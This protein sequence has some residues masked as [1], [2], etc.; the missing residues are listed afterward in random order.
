M[1]IESL[2]KPPGPAHVNEAHAR[3]GSAVPKANTGE[4]VQLS[5]LASTLQKAEAALAETPEVDGKRIEEIK[6][7]IRDGRFQIDANRIADGLLAEVRQMLD[8]QA[9]RI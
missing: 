9:D 6:Q 2:G 5:P 7:A 1:K 3:P 8:N 4:S